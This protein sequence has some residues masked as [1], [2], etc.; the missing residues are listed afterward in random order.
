MRHQHNLLIKSEKADESKTSSDDGLM[1]A[2][3]WF[4]N[5]NSLVSLMVRLLTAFITNLNT[6][7][8][9]DLQ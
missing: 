6:C 3:T 8:W 5:S 4:Q 7:L 9:L 1:N 2:P